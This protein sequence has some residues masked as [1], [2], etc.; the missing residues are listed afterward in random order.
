[1]FVFMGMPAAAVM[2]MGMMDMFVLV[3]VPAAAVM[4][5]GMMDMFVFRGVSAATGLPVGMVFLTVPVRMAV[6]AGIP[7]PDDNIRFQFMGNCCNLC[8]KLL[9]LFG[10]MPELFGGKGNC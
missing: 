3:D 10:F 9:R 6:R 7:F 5:M 2:V 8:K 1:M 4:V